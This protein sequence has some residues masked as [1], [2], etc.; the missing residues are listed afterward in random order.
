MLTTKAER[1]SVVAVEKCHECEKMAEEK[2][3]RWLI[4]GEKEKGFDWM[5]LCIQCVRN[6]RAR[7]LGREGLSSK[8]IAV[9]LDKDYP[10]N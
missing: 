6:W 8:E 10:L 3:G 9:E 2:K 5:F 4:L 1:L 7:G